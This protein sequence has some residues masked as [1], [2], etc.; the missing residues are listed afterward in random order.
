M[1][2]ISCIAR[3]IVCNTASCD[4]KDAERSCN[5]IRDI[6]P[7]DTMQYTKPISDDR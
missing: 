1:Q 3:N 7:Y 4:W 2:P 6:Q 5:Y